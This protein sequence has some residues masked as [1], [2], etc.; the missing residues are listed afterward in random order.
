MKK[1]LASLLGLWLLLSSFSSQAEIHALIMTIGN[2]QGGI[3]QLKG[4]MHDSESAHSIAR[5]MGVR[6]ENILQFHD[7]QLNLNGMQQA[8]DELDKRVAPG[9]KVFIY[10]SGHGGR[11]QVKDPEERCAES[12]VTVDGYGLIDSEM[13]A[14]LKKLS[15]R[16]Q[17][18]IAM[19]DSCHSGG[20]TTRGLSNPMFTPKYWSKGGEG[21]NACEK[22]VNVVTRGIKLASQA[23]GSG[24]KNYVYIAAAND[25]EV[26]LDQSSKGG[27]ATAA[28]LECMSGGAKD[29]DGSGGLTVEEIRSC[30]QEKIDSQMQGAQG[31]LPQHINIIGNPQ[32]VMTLVAKNIQTP[33]EP[34]SGIAPNLRPNTDS[35]APATLR[36]IFNGRD[37]RR[38]VEIIPAQNKLKIDHDKFSVGIRTNNAGYLYL[39]MV[40]SDGQTFDIL[41]PNKLDENNYIQADKTVQFPRSGW[42]VV[43]QGPVGNDHILAIVSD[44]PRDFSKLSMNNAGPF[45][46][47]TATPGGKRGI[48]LVTATPTLQS[49]TECSEPRKRNLAVKQV[50]SDAYGAALAVIEE[51]Q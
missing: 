34:V 23:T 37:D 41:F 24:G 36:D 2:Y 49:Q 20:V 8:F 9:D 35:G 13:E 11:Q 3:P 19:F 18:I 50:C 32:L 39:L 21:V 27:L 33:S 44:A 12:L 51:A 5:L 1:F 46:A 43:A 29:L 42:E 30:A 25:N 28:W 26:S 48:H 31:F 7:A 40:G 47:V 15:G 14:R 16:T 22:P 4:V 17:K 6:E 10:Y 38:I 45:S